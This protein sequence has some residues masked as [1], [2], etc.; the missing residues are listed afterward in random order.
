MDI[1]SIKG[2][3]HLI[4]KLGLGHLSTVTFLS[5]FLA[6]V[7]MAPKIFANVSS[8][9]R[10]RKT[11]LCSHTQTLQEIA[12]EKQKSEH[13]PTSYSS[14]YLQ[15]NYLASSNSQMQPPPTTVYAFIIT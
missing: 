5:I 9:I 7:S 10:Y 8:P 13:A 11:R 14:E 12:W 4:R 1:L 15:I 6:S 2:V 3:R